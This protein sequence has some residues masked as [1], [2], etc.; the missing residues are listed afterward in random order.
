MNKKFGIRSYVRDRIFPFVP[1][2]RS[3]GTKTFNGRHAAGRNRCR[4][5]SERIFCRFYSFEFTVSGRSKSLKI[6]RGIL[7]A[8]LLT[9]DPST[10]RKSSLVNAACFF[11]VLAYKFVVTFATN[12]RFYEGE[13][14]LE[15]KNLCQI[16]PSFMKKTFLSFLSIIF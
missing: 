2:I 16:I 13:Y 3:R 15:K 7:N 5:A 1:R 8:F 10:T 4:C 9:A 11:F 6:L 12:L 14:F